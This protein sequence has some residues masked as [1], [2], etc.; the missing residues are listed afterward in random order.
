M[1]E[2][3]GRVPRHMGVLADAMSK[4][5]RKWT[6]RSLVERL[7]EAV[8]VDVFGPDLVMPDDV[9]E[10]GRLRSAFSRK[11]NG[12]AAVLHV[13]V[14]AAD[15][16]GQVWLKQDTIGERVGRSARQ[17]RRILLDLE[18]LGLIE[19]RYAVALNRGGVSIWT[20]DRPTGGRRGGSVYQLAIGAQSTPTALPWEVVE[21]T[22]GTVSQSTL[23][24]GHLDRTGGISA[25][26]ARPNVRPEPVAMSAHMNL[27]ERKSST[28]AAEHPASGPC[29][30]WLDDPPQHDES[31]RLSISTTPVQS[32]RGMTNVRHEP[33][34]PFLASEPLRCD[35]IANAGTTTP[36][37]RPTDTASAG[38]DATTTAPTEP[39]GTA[40]DDASAG[41][42]GLQRRLR[43]RLALG[44]PDMTPQ[45]VELCAA[46][47][48]MHPWDGM[49]KL[50]E[51]LAR[52]S[53]K[54]N[55]A[56]YIKRAVTAEAT[57]PSA[58]PA[59]R[60]SAD[61]GGSAG[62]RAAWGEA[63]NAGGR[64]VQETLDQLEREAVRRFQELTGQEVYA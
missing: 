2:L 47:L 39:T 37:P 19:A 52:A 34:V 32:T 16:R 35:A 46:S 50:E 36:A 42:D 30:V 22:A 20:G 62:S 44:C 51:I 18:R 12:M 23:S 24:T 11:R 5:A 10:L 54:R 58:P 21:T 55:P 13:M 17:V 29:R 28:A 57:A 8:M 56:G 26:S 3:V 63:L 49:A 31:G 64:D 1:A 7:E 40:S 25:D 38:S 14:W 27:D 43:N 4:E 59:A 53:G 9:T 48:A 60:P 6:E 45:V 41:S 33:D 61:G 15:R